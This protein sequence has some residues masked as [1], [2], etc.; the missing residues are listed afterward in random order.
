MKFARQA[1]RVIGD[2]TSRRRELLIYGSAIKTSDNQLICNRY[3]FLIGGK[4]GAKIRSPHRTR[5]AIATQ[6]GLDESNHWA[7]TTLAPYVLR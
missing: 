1:G 2:E 4:R 7:F 5:T 3:K 6:E